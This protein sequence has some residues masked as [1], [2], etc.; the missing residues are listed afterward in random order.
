MRRNLWNNGFWHPSAIADKS[1]KAVQ[2]GH[3]D[4]TG[5]GTVD[6]HI[7]PCEPARQT[8]KGA[9]ANGA[10]C[11]RSS[12]LKRDR[13]L[14]QRGR[15]PMTLTRSKSSPQPPSDVWSSF[16]AYAKGIINSA[17]WAEAKRQAD[18]TR[19]DQRTPIQQPIDDCRSLGAVSASIKLRQKFA[20]RRDQCSPERKERRDQRRT[21]GAD[22]TMPDHVRRRYTEGERAVQRI[23]A[24]EV[25]RKGYCDLYIDEIGRRA[26]V[27]RT[28]VQNAIRQGIACG[29]ITRTPQRISATKNAPNIIRIVSREWLTW[30]TR[31]PAMFIR[32]REGTEVGLTRPNPNGFL[33]ATKSQSQT[34][35]PVP[36][37][38]QDRIRA[39]SG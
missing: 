3:S 14:C 16:A 37:D 8:T 10:L 15:S 5:V 25:L 21:L 1:D 18:L 12:F 20:P 27:A 9:A 17:E 36:A 31:G 4:R 28:T 22:G 7:S 6:R 24:G 26:G 19:Q 32:V 38:R 34:Q 13:R 35:K 23:I 39:E 11:N 2:T 33:S 29:H 30:L